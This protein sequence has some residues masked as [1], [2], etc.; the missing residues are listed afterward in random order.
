[1]YE[2]EDAE[3]GT[4]AVLETETR[5]QP[6]TALVDCGGVL[7]LVEAEFV[8]K[9]PDTGNEYRFFVAETRN[10]D[11]DLMGYVFGNLE[12]DKLLD[13]AQDALREVL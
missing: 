4:M 3:P 12:L 11:G 8:H 2:F 10:C 7:A 5:W 6:Y 1:M 13:T 9:C